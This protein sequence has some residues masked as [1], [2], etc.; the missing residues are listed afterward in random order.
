[1][2]R[3][4][5]GKLSAEIKLSEGINFLLPIEINWALIGM[6]AFILSC[7]VFN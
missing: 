2:N 7:L 6:A 5:I 4:G 3:N 1:M